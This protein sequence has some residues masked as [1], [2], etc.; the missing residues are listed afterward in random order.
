MNN[1][2]ITVTLDPV[3]LDRL[4][5]FVRGQAA[6]MQL[7]RDAYTGQEGRKLAEQGA[8]AAISVTAALIKGLPATGLGTLGDALAELGP[9]RPS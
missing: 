2:P 8:Q 4:E 1:P 5:T 6:Y 3:L 9:Y 7:S